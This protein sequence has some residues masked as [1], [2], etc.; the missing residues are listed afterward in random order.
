[1]ENCIMNETKNK[2]VTPSLL[3]YVCPD[4]WSDQKKEANPIDAEEIV[5]AIKDGKEVEII[6]AV[7]EGSFILRSLNVESEVSIQRTKIKGPLDWSYATFKRVLNFENSIFETDAT[8]KAVTVEKDMFLDNVTFGG[9]AAFSDITVLGIFYS[10]SAN[11]KKQSIFT[12]G[13]FKKRIELN[14]SKFE[15]E[16]NFVSARIGSVAVFTGA[17]FKERAIFNG[18]QIGEGAFFNP[19]TF[20]GEANFVSARIGSSAVF[21]GAEFKEQAIF[22]GAQ[23]GEG[24]FFNP[25]TFEGE[26]NFVSARIG[27]SAVFTG[28]EFKEQAS[29]SCAQIDGPAFFDLATFEGEANFVSARIG[30]S[31][32]FTGAEFKERASFNKTQIDGSA[33][34]DLA[35]FEGEAN[36]V[37]A[38]IGSSAEFT[39]AEFKERASFNSAQ[40]QRE[41]HFERTI[42][43]NYVSFENTSFE[44][45]YFGEPEVQF[46]AKIDLRGC[47]YN[48]I[49]PILFWEQ[50]MEYLDPY[51]RQPFTQ[52]EETFRRAGKDKLADDVY[53]EL[54]CRESDQKTLRNPGAWLLDHFLW[55]FTGYGVRLHRLSVFIALILLIGTII[56]HFEGAVEPKLDMQP[57]PHLPYWEAFWVSLNTFLPVEIPSGENWIPSSKIIRVLGI[58]FTT[59]AT[60]LKLAGW[61]LIPVGIAGISG[62][63]KR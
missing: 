17:E 47:I 61:I 63:L 50:L 33:F 56:F 29:F 42:F 5:E 49:H 13:N 62:I 52:L 22:N 19:A 38:R 1:M 23:I 60:L 25:A 7:I 45:I 10:R 41:S 46:N 35:T 36:F 8:F 54:K 51:D 26:A 55:L 6:N 37:S 32:E 3:K 39:G 12:E 11:Y 59:F 43:A 2:E 9:F 21:T 20:E 57:L 15:G 14:K 48:R 4:N 28:S 34:F 18:A 24:A 44:T 27:S 40:I 31:A 53:Y 58:R 16:A 30:S